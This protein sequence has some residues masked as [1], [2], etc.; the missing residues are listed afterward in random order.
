MNYQS[1]CNNLEIDNINHLTIEIPLK[2]IHKFFT[3]LIKI[4]IHGWRA[5]PLPGVLPGFKLN[6]EI[7]QFYPEG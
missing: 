3:F 1:A 7:R 2:L 5:G 6:F 4:K